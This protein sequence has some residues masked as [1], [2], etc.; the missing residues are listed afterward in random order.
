M[1]EDRPYYK[2]CDGKYRYLDKRAAVGAMNKLNTGRTAGEVRRTGIH[3]YPCDYCAGWHL[4][5]GG[6]A[7]HA[8][9]ERKE[10][11]AARHGEK[12]THRLKRRRQLDRARERE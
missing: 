7:E 3:V 10:T 2:G 9:I 6:S 8:A 12:R 11:R 1:S 4:G 5:K